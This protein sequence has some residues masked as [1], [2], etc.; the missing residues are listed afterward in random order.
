MD[1]L[2]RKERKEEE[3]PENWCASYLKHKEIYVHEKP[4][5]GR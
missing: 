2:E 4:H 3:L 1:D 5:C